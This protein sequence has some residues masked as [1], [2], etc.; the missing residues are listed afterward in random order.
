MTQPP[1]PPTSNERLLAFVDEVAQ[2]TQTEGVEWCDGSQEEYDRL[3][4]LLV[5]NGTFERLD[6]A[7]RPNSYLALSDPADVARVEDRTFICSE[8]EIDAGP[9]NNWMDPAEMRSLMTDLYRGCMRG[10]TMY[11]VPF[12]MGPLGAE[13]P[14]LGVEITDSEYVVISMRTMT[15]M[16]QAA[17]QDFERRRKDGGRSRAVIIAEARRWIG[18]L[19]EFPPHHRLAADADGNSVHVGGEHSPR[20]FIHGARKLQD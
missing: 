4:A 18:G 6:D 16:G 15:R 9:T 17:L 1:N 12:C 8:R 13:D 19:D 3:C 11:V 10:R 5:E 7:K 20:G 2:L 14:K